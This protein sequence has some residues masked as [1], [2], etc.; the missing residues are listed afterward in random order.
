MV[1]RIIIVNIMMFISCILYCNTASANTVISL[2]YTSTSV[3]E[4]DSKTIV[5]STNP[6]GLNISWSS[7]NTS[8]ATVNNGIVTGIKAR[9]TPVIITASVVMNNT[10]YSAECEVYVTTSNGVYYLKNQKSNYYLHVKG[11][12]IKNYTDVIQEQKY[13]TSESNEKKIWY[14]RYFIRVGRCIQMDN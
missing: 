11:G 3:N 8:V 4:G 5:A 6:S 7:S 10:V 14:Y 2:N 13:N 9:S 12:K 1:N